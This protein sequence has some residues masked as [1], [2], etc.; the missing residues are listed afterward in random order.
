MDIDKSQ[1]R[2]S[3]LINLNLDQTHLINK[4][5]CGSDWVEFS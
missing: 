2:L 3:N 5:R 4:A 1:I